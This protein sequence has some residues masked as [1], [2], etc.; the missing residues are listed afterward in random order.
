M[1]NISK[2]TAWGYEIPGSSCTYS[3][4]MKGSWT[5]TVSVPWY[6]NLK[7]GATSTRDASGWRNPLPYDREVIRNGGN[8]GLVTV[9]FTG[10]IRSDT[11]PG[12]K[13]P[14][15]IYWGAPVNR[16]L[17]APQLPAY[18]DSLLRRAEVEALLK[19]KDRGPNLAEAFGERR[20][21]VR[22][23]T[24]V[25]TV[26]LRAIKYARRHSWLDCASTLGTTL[27]RGWRN[28][29]LWADGWLQLWYGWLPLYQTVY[30]AVKQLNDNDLNRPERYTV[31][32][33]RNITEKDVDQVEGTWSLN[34]SYHRIGYRSTRETQFRA[35]VRLDFVLSNPRLAALSQWGITNP[36]DLTYQLTR[37]SFVLDWWLPIGDLLSALDATLGWSFKGGSKTTVTKSE[38]KI[39]TPTDD[40]VFTN[41]SVEVSGS[42]NG[43]IS[44]ADGAPWSYVYHN[45]DVYGSPP[46]NWL[47]YFNDTFNAK[48]LVT[49]IALLVQQAR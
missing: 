26:L 12:C 18:P 27:K 5:S 48:K 8:S 3:N 43:S 39:V 23:V 2:A 31:H 17:V 15:H 6:S 9:F 35:K 14:Q 32:V 4:C 46:T 7:V 44:S 24:N 10:D 1:T 25:V 30:D 38:V 36:W 40:T 20:E 11:K 49:L 19:L 37:L 22:M 45:R 34:S 42:V 16:Q 28:P 33:V 21:T 29:R 13:C 41:R 47:P